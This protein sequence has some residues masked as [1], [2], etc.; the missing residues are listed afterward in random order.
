MVLSGVERLREQSLVYVAS[1]LVV[2]CVDAV[3]PGVLLRCQIEP[4]I[5]GQLLLHVINESFFPIFFCH[6]L[7]GL[8]V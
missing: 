4:K 2:G 6:L 5:V 8:V 3:S 7:E 1:I